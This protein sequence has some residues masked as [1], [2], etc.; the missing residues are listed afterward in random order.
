[1]IR[2]KYSSSRIVELEI[3]VRGLGYESEHREKLE[4]VVVELNNIEVAELINDL[5]DTANVTGIK[6]Q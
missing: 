5:M 2:V 4:T 3:E 6:R 1:M